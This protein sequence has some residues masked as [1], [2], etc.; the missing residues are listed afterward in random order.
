VAALG[1]STVLVGLGLWL[2]RIPLAEFFI[3]SA[4][5]ERGAEA[6]FRVINLD[7][8]GVT[9]ADVRFGAET[10]PDAAIGVVQARWRW[11]GLSPRLEAVRLV[12]PRVRLRLDQR[13]RVSAGALD[14]LGGGPPGRR[15]PTLPRL[16]LEIVDG[17]IL[18]EAP[19]GALVAP[20]RGEG[21]LGE[22]FALLG[23]IEPT[24]RARG[25]YAIEDGAAELRIVSQ[26]DAIGARLQVSAERVQWAGADLDGGSLLAVANAPLDLSQ[27]QANVTWRVNA[28]DANGFA[29]TQFAG[30]AE[31]EASMRSDALV[32]AEWTAQARIAAAAFSGD[33]LDMRHPRFEAHAEGNAGVGQARWTLGAD[34]FA[35]FAMIS[36]QPAAAGRLY[37]DESRNWSGNVLLTLAQTALNADAQSSLRRAFP[38]LASAPIGPTFARAE[39]TL[40]SAADRFT[41]SMPLVLGQGPAGPQLIMVDAAEARAANGVLVRLSP[42][43]RDT[44][45]MMLQWPGPTLG[46]A[47][48]LELSGGGGPHAELLLDTMSWAPQAPFE[49]D[50]TL[51]LSNWR[52]TGA[53]I[54]A[55]ELGI[56]I[57]V[58]PQNG[59]RIDLR[60]PVRVTG[61]L[62]DGE[63]RDLSPTLNVSIAWGDGWRVTTNNNACVPT[64]LGGLDA[65]GL[66]FAGGAFSLCPLG[67]ALI[68]ADRADNLS[69]GFQIQSLALN[70]RMAGPDAQ[71]TRLS[72]GNVVGR[73]R[74]RTGDMTLALEANAPRLTIEMD[75]DRTLAVTLRRIL[76]NARISDSWSIDGSFE[77]GTL[78]DPSLPGSVSTIEGGWSA[79]PVDGKP[80]IRVTAG[81][82]L[83]TAH[84]PASDAERLLFNPMRLADVDATLREGRIDATGAII[85]A[86]REN[87]LARFTASHEVSE[88]AGG[89]QIVANNIAFLPSLQ[90]YDIS[91]RTR[92]LVDNVRGHADLVADAAWTRETFTT[93][94]R[95]RL[96]NVS[97]TTATIPVVDNVN[98]EIFFDDLLALTTPPG[99]RLQVGLL[100]PGVAVSDGTVRFQLLGD[101]RVAIE[102]ASFNYASGILEMRP[103][104]ITLGADET[105]FEL[106][107]RDVDAAELLSTLNVPDLTATGRL[108]GAFPLLLTRTSAYVHGGVVRAQG[109]GGVIAYTGNAGAN[110]TGAARIAFDALRS[111]RYDALSLTLD[112]DLNGDVVSSIEFSGRNSGRPVDLGPIAPVPGL[113]RVT[114]RGV[115][116]VFNVRVEAPFRRLAQ[117]AATITDP[118]SLLNQQ[119]DEPEQEEAVDQEAPAPR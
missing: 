10:S 41:L 95:L 4:L 7:L 55:N 64:R 14:R 88:G 29:A 11:S 67:G 24:S 119:E 63:V 79:A 73:F 61:P 52:A 104:T 91:E 60:G 49:A 50:G 57:E 51:S 98:G 87:Q 8:N 115:P 71:P 35:G 36:E 117:T 111:F 20:M 12:E 43:R 89:A 75:E 97:L 33:E 28:I 62:G 78:S 68:A 32:I 69:G 38:D 70:G 13:G 101:Q 22:N 26:R 102:D 17:Q 16:E 34:R 108:E 23:R 83:L 93:T 40:D 21:R 5:A 110:S 3:G 48:A 42:L 47:I 1:V 85:L 86:A 76:A 72:A 112:G 109:E 74:G 59:G 2:A 96:R 53:S 45:A 94:G 25:E 114:V 54:A 90:P 18:V 27:A 113:G 103:T 66:S 44:P 58:R 65:A 81:E 80:V 30:V 107:L 100:N 84:R 99:Q 92:G 105:R 46:G 56:T 6:D 19:F 77:S 15:R 39:Q 9:L 31:T 37:R 116:F 106:R 118:G 82:A